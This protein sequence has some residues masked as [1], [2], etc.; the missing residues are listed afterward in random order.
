MLAERRCT[1]IRY[2]LEGELE[3]SGARP[4]PREGGL[5]VG[6]SKGP[7][8]IAGAAWGVRS[9]WGGLIEDGIIT[10]P[11][12]GSCAGVGIGGNSLSVIFHS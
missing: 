3:R 10:L 2:V 5:G 12:A 9:R 4:P 7:C 11:L 1:L 8:G 6:Q